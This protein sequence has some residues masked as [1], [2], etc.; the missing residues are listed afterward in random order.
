MAYL[1]PTQKATL[2]GL[3][4]AIDDPSINKNNNAAVANHLNRPIRVVTPGGTATRYV[5]LAEIQALG[6]RLKVIPKLEAALEGPA[7]VL[8]R[9]TLNLFTSKVDPVNVQDAAFGEMLDQLVAATLLTTQ[10]RTAIE[11]LAVVDAPDVVTET[12]VFAQ[13]FPDFEYR[14]DGSRYAAFAHPDL[15]A[16]A[17]A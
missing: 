7:R 6:Y 3:I 2:A 17:R 9:I 15:I 14:I 8:A 12:T 5:P 10:E 16:E 11:A 13:A 1:T 4:A